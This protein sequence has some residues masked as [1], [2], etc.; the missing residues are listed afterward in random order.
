MRKSITIPKSCFSPPVYP[1]S[2][3]TDY[4]DG[5]TVC[6]MDPGKKQQIV[7]QPNFPRSPKR[8]STS[9][10]EIK[11]SSHGLGV[12]ATRDL[13]PGELIM[14]ERPLFVYP[15]N[16]LHGFVVSHP[17]YFTKEQKRLGDF[18]EREKMLKY[19]FDRMFPEDQQALLA[20]FVPPGHVG[21][22]VI[23]SRISTNSFGL[24]ENLKYRDQGR[25]DAYGALSKDLCRINHR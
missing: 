3:F 19:L 20:L 11:A 16:V 5:V 15:Q 23:Q 2:K 13:E 10:Y 6:M 25:W 8:P 18:R 9:A 14:G 4:P 7:T 24:P 21:T 17:D 1:D 12:F 22:G